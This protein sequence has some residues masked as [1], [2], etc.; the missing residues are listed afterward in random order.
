MYVVNFSTRLVSSLYGV[1][2]VKVF[3]S[4]RELFPSMLINQF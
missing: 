3:S 1:P 4:H 2:V